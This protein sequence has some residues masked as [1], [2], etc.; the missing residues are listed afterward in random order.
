MSDPWDAPD[1]QTQSTPPEILSALECAQVRARQSLVY[2]L[3][4]GHDPAH[5]FQPS[6]SP[7]AYDCSGAASDVIHR[8][9]PLP[10]AMDTGELLTTPLLADGPGEYLTIWI[11]QYPDVIE[12]VALQ[13]KIP[14]QPDHRWWM[15]SHPDGRPEVGFVDLQDEWVLSP[16]IY[17]PRRRL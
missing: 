10:H 13:F 6:G 12:H 15:A 17:K 14:G 4:G 1:G 11:A 5:P 16:F 9:A 7:L 8:F 3:G 2:R